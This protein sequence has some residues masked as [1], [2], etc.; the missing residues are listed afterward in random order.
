MLS[1]IFVRRIKRGTPFTISGPL[2]TR[3]PDLI[4]SLWNDKFK[5]SLIAFL[6]EYWK[7]ALEC[8]E[9][10]KEKNYT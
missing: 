9:W 10:L 4:K 7:D 2:Q 1:E 8:T 5:D 6:V 3:P